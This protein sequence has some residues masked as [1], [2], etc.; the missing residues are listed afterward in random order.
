MIVYQFTTSKPAQSG[1]ENESWYAVTE[2]GRV[3]ASHV[4][5]SRT[6]GILDTGPD[7]F[8]ASKYPRDAKVIV[9]PEGAYPPEHV[10]KAAGFV[11][12]VTKE[13]DERAEFDG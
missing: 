3:I 10:L 12:H 13:Q 6:W 5:S 2:E 4:S 11:R 1:W 9:L 7:G 8:Y